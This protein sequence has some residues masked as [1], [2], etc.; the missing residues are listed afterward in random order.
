MS[1]VGGLTCRSQLPIRS[2]TPLAST[3]LVSRR[4]LRPSRPTNCCRRP[5]PRQ[6]AS[7]LNARVRHNIVD[8]RKILSEEVKLLSSQRDQLAYE[9]EL[10]N[11]AGHAP[12]ELIE[13]YCTLFDPK[14]LNFVSEFSREEL[15]LI[16]H[17]YG[18]LVEA[19]RQEFLTV[20]EMLKDEKWRRVLSIASQLY[21]LLTGR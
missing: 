18:L 9:S 3:A 19:S 17:L 8:V 7:Q 16:A 6:T 2:V 14:S 12:S 1:F 5:G 11:S 10:T 13:G 15:K 21:S 20:A 4:I